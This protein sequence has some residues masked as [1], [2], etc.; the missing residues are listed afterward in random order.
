MITSELELRSVCLQ[1]FCYHRLTLLSVLSS[2][3]PLYCLI[4]NPLR[5]DGM[6]YQL[7]VSGSGEVSGPG[8]TLES[9]NGKPSLRPGLGSAS[10][11]LPCS[12]VLP[13]PRRLHRL[14]LDTSA[15]GASKGWHRAGSQIQVTEPRVGVP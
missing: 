10:T 12:S 1:G 2:L 5:H 8:S 9:S 13:P 15:P 11:F 14:W 6:N 4:L 7:Q 3:L